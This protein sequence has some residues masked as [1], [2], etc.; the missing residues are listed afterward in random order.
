M[1]TRNYRGE[2]KQ[3]ENH[4]SGLYIKRTALG[5]AVGLL[6][7]GEKITFRGGRS[8]VRANA[9]NR[10]Q[11]INADIHSVTQ[12]ADH[13]KQIATDVE[14]REGEL[15]QCVRCNTMFRSKFGGA[16][17]GNA[18]DVMGSNHDLARQGWLC[19]DCWPMASEVYQNIMAYYGAHV[20]ITQKRF[21][22]GYRIMADGGMVTTEGEFDSVEDV[23]SA[24]HLLAARRMANACVC[25]WFDRHEDSVVAGYSRNGNPY[26]RTVVTFSGRAQAVRVEPDM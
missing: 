3:K 17:P 15:A 20:G 12:E 21:I 1:D 26:Y 13:L 18:V 10:I 25:F 11:A 19:Q 23:K 2:I 16:L 22:P 6:W 8:Q 9:E 14:A 24:L 7:I 4:I 5:S